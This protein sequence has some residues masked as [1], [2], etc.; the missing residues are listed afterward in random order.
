MRSTWIKNRNWVADTY[1]TKNTCVSRLPRGSLLR[2]LILII[3]ESVPTKRWLA[4][5]TPLPVMVPTIDL[6]WPVIQWRFQNLA[7]LL[8]LDE[9]RFGFS[10]FLTL[11]NAWKIWDKMAPASQHAWRQL[12]C[13]SQLK[14]SAAASCLLCR[15]GRCFVFKYV[16][17]VA[18]CGHA[19]IA[20][21]TAIHSPTMD[22]PKTRFP[23]WVLIFGKSNPSSLPSLVGF[24]DFVKI[25]AAGTSIMLWANLYINANLRYFILRIIPFGPFSSGNTLFPKNH[26]WIFVSLWSNPW[27]SLVSIRIAQDSIKGA[28]W[29]DQ[30][31]LRKLVLL[32]AQP[33]LTWYT[34]LAILDT[35]EFSWFFRLKFS[36]SWTPR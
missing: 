7:L 28:M 13:S 33:R 5:F 35:V 23:A 15:V 8:Q 18:M 9:K 32:H 12:I 4:P 3:W 24:W 20:A 16:L 6:Q 36:Q 27:F 21:G 25:S 14:R 19:L 22:D 1:G 31:L 10:I 11:V 26:F 34:F 30:I 17:N 2:F 29:N